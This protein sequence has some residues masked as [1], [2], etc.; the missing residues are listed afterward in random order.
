MQPGEQAH[1]L[2]VFHRLCSQTEDLSA[3]Q[4]CDLLVAALLH[5]VGKSRRP[6]RLWERVWIVVGQALLPGLAGRLGEGSGEGPVRAWQRP[7]VV[8]AQHPAW[9]A[10][11]AAEAGTSPLAVAIIRRH[12][13]HSPPNGVTIE[14]VLLQRLQAVDGNQ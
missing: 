13:N 2:M 6:L 3:E 5:D 11:L 9:G 14:E 4:R 8:A 10:E 12:Q 7:F 1:S